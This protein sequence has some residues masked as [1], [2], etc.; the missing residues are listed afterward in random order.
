VI[1][2]L[3]WAR[4]ILYTNRL[5][6]RFPGSVIYHGAVADGG[7]VL[8]ENSVLFRGAVLTESKLGAYSYVQ[9]GSA[10]YNAEIGSFCSIASAVTIGLGSHPTSM[11]S[12]SPVFYDKDQP[13]PKFF[14]KERVY[15]KMFPRTVIGAD[16]WIGQGAIVKA[17]VRIGVGAV[18]GSASMV[19]K[20]V[21]PYTIAAGNPCRPI[22]LRFPEDI[23][24]RLVESHWWDLHESK[25][26]E[27]ARLFADPETFLAALSYVHE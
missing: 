25:L 1:P 16:V 22:R 14:V 2:G 18:I 19:T 12:T 4:Q 21:P 17:G 11:V 3:E 10:V 24:R 6:R 26:N 15:T 9:S 27:L 20:D 23:C 13:L 5:R 7:C 8:G